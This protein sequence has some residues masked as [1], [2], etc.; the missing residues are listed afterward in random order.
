[1][2][3]PASRTA[4]SAST[5]TV[6]SSQTTCTTTSRGHTH[7]DVALAGAISAFARPPP[8][9]SP[10]LPSTTTTTTTKTT[11]TSAGAGGALA[12]AAHARH[13]SNQ[14]PSPRHGARTNTPGPRASRRSPS[15]ATSPLLGSSPTGSL[16]SVSSSTGRQK[17]TRHQ[18]VL[19]PNKL[20]NLT[21]PSSSRQERSKS[22]SHHAAQAAA[23]RAPAPQA[24]RQVKPVRPRA[25]CITTQRPATAPKPRRLSDHLKQQ[26]TAPDRSTDDSPIQPT[27]SLVKLFEDKAGAASHPNTIVVSRPSSDLTV[28]SPNPQTK[29]DGGITSMFQMELEHRKAPPDANSR[30]PIETQGHDVAALQTEDR[31]PDDEEFVSASEDTAGPESPVSNPGRRD[32]GAPSIMSVTSVDVTSAYGTSHR[33]PSPRRHTHSVQPMPIRQSAPRNITSPVTAPRPSTS[34]PSLQAQYN[35]LNPRRMTPLNTGDD[36]ANALVASSLASSMASSRAGSP[37]KADMPPPPPSRRHKHHKLTFSRTPSPTKQHVMRQTLRKVQ[38]DD[39]ASEDELHPYHKHQKKRLVR[40][41][42]NKHH[43]GDRKRW[44]DAVTERER[45]RYEGVWAANKG[46][47][48]TFPPEERALIHN[49]TNSQPVLDLHS[50]AAEQVSNIVV[51][52]IWS[53]SRLPD[54]TLEVVWDLVDE[55]LT[56]R[57]TKEQFVVGMWLID[58]RLKGR[59][60]PTRIQDSVWASVRSIHG[61]KIRKY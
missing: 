19:D 47:Y 52:D 27:T 24:S 5:T 17:H 6:D 9:S 4:S 14:T 31:T 53:R 54:A 25:T 37:R 61:I 50:Q 35:Q 26:S 34:G 60:L 23:A 15:P 42:P 56:G 8:H 36:L 55:D 22:P 43:E 40:K 59:K 58:L 46:L 44:R 1:M 32:S 49:S 41:H 48:C 3:R 29:P 13:R 7:H 30:P 57:L 12:A 2:P 39:S 21:V 18:L 38:S 28:R 20:P 33:R 16:G 11:T 10:R 45:R 51:R